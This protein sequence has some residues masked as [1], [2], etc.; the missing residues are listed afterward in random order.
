M[1]TQA[2]ILTQLNKPLEIWELE[3]PKIKRGQVL[4]QIS[5]S[6]L[7]HTQ[8]NEWKGAKGHDPYLPHTL[9]H[10]GSGEVLEIGE[11]VTKVKP[12]DKVVLSWIKG[13]GKNHFITGLQHLYG[14]GRCFGE[15]GHPNP[16]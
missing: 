3:I 13:Q 5:Y 16:S 8:L 1:K 9:G 2:A 14:K 12:G 4:V 7:C 15:S 10:E 11:G 6:G